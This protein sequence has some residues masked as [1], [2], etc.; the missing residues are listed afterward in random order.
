[1]EAAMH[2]H[3]DGREIWTLNPSTIIDPPASGP[4]S[5]AGRTDRLMNVVGPLVAFT[6]VI[7]MALVLVSESQ[8]PPELRQASWEMSHT[9]P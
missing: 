2:H 9:F 4:I 8:L 1:L 7:T 5:E 3:A 6:A